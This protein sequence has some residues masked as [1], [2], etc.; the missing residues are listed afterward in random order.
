M[1][2]SV[3]VAEILKDRPSWFRDCRCLDILS[4]IPTGSGGTI[5]LIYMQVC[6]FVC[7][8]LGLALASFWA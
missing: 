7:C 3:Q 5:E 6:I 2:V 4:V 1:N 8:V